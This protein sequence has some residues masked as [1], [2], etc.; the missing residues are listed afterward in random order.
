MTIEDAA[1]RAE[2]FEAARIRAYRQARIFEPS[3]E[4]YHAAMSVYAAAFGPPDGEPTVV[5][6]DGSTKQGWELDK[7]VARVDP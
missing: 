6:P 5:F 1:R 2:E 7:D 3:A 4:A